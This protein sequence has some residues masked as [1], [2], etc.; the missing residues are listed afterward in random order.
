MALYGIVEHVTPNKTSALMAGPTGQMLSYKAKRKQNNTRSH[1]MATGTKQTQLRSVG[2][3]TTGSGSA[4]VPDIAEG[5]QREDTGT[6]QTQARYL[7]A[8]PGYT[9]HSH[10]YRPE[11]KITSS[12]NCSAVDSVPSSNKSTISEQKDICKKMV[13][14]LEKLKK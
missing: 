3:D 4:P 7:T 1:Y 6:D 9:L 11:F 12:T 13:N 10:S 5:L 8:Q 2:S 14:M